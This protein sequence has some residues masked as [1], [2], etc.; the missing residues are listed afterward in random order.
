MTDQAQV[1]D[2]SSVLLSDNSTLTD[3]EWEHKY[4][5]GMK[6]RN[7][8]FPADPNV[9]D[10]QLQSYPLFQTHTIDTTDS[11]DHNGIQQ[12]IDTEVSPVERAESYKL[13]GN[14][15]FQLAKQIKI[16]HD[17]HV[18][19]RDELQLQLQKL[20]SVD[21]QQQIQKLDE[22]I[23]NEQS[24]YNKRLS[25][26]LIYYQNGVDIQCSDRLVN[27]Q[28]YINCCK[29]YFIQN[30]Y[31][32]CLR[33][34][35]HIIAAYDHKMSKAYYYCIYSCIKLV[36]LEQAQQYI[37]QY[38]QMIRDK[39][40]TNMNYNHEFNKLQ[41]IL[42]DTIKHEQSLIDQQNQ[43]KSDKEAHQLQLENVLQ[44]YNVS[45]AHDIDTSVFP[46]QI[47][48]V[49][50]EL[51]IPVLLCYPQYNQT[52][53]IQ[54]MNINDTLYNM[55]S[56]VLPPKNSYA[57]WDINHEYTVG[58][59]ICY[60]DTP[61]QQYNITDLNHDI[62]QVKYELYINKNDQQQYVRVYFSNLQ[63]SLRQLYNNKLLQ[64]I[65]YKLPGVAVIHIMNQSMTICAEC[66]T[67][68]NK[69]MYCSQCHTTSYCSVNCQRKHWKYHKLQCNRNNKQQNK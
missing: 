36:R 51:I 47:R 41:N 35:Q 18:S 60:I 16:N 40:I 24:S 68:Q 31:G 34:A 54:S 11:I 57:E 10:H 62:N 67:I 5:N 66:H 28:L 15:V 29:I 4:R 14:D 33:T 2:I 1:N 13:S 43:L 7:V 52:D 6:Q 27:S 69:K 12:I 45:V 25:D 26:A 32:L 56:I 20:H 64:H 63:L 46:S 17:R 30:R 50:H 53:F 21:V 48:L 3:T 61:L 9:L 58:T 8:A 23:I 65:Q 22:Q 55:L 59:V 37:N 19:K 38:N 42:N 44:Q 39:V 49:G